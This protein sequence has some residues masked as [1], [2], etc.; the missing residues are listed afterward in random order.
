MD[1]NRRWAKKNHTTLLESYNTGANTLSFIAKECTQHASTLSV[2]A[3]SLENMNRPKNEIKIINQ[4]LNDTLDNK[5]SFLHENQIKFQLIGNKTLL[6]DNTLRK[7]EKLEQDTQHFTKMTLNVCF[8]YS[9]KWDIANAINKI[10][11]TTT[12]YQEITEEN[13]QKNLSISN[14]DLCIRV[15]G[16]TRLSNFAI[17]QNAY[18]EIFFSSTLWPDFTTNELIQIIEEYKKKNRRFGK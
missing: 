10:N 5:F 11:N 15:S 2:F 17:W 1:G 16:E 13:I 4:V 14:I 6:K 9:G 18:S 7:I 8:Y 12:N 3:F